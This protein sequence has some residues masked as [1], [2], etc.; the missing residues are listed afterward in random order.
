VAR[1]TVSLPAGLQLTGASVVVFG[2]GMVAATFVDECLQAGAQVRLISP[3]ACSALQELARAHLISWSKRTYA[4]GDL[5][6]AQLA[7]AGSVEIRV[8]RAVQDEAAHRHVACLFDDAVL[9]GAPQLP[10]QRPPIEDS[11]SFP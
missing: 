5:A 4:R 3:W 2:S 1:V 9:G 7:F 6:G 10:G 11:P 8:D